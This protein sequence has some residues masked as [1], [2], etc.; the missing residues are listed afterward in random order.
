M[1]CNAKPEV[2]VIVRYPKQKAMIIHFNEFSTPFSP[3]KIFR[4]PY[5]VI[6]TMINLTTI[7]IFFPRLAGGTKSYNTIRNISIH[8]GLCTYNGILANYNGL[9]N[10]YI[11]T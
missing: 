6:A 4:T 3:N 1:G 2:I 11:A 10:S 8:Q 7:I 5:K 9:Q